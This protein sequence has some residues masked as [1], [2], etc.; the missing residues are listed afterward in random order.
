MTALTALAKRFSLQRLLVFLIAAMLIVAG[1]RFVR[2]RT[3]PRLISGPMLALS[4][5]GTPAIRWSAE[6][7]SQTQSVRLQAA[8]GREQTIGDDGGVARL[9]GLPP[10]TRFKYSVHA[11]WGGWIDHTVAGPFEARVPPGRKEP[12]RFVAFGDSGE[13]GNAQFDLARVM[14]S[15]RP[16]LIIH[17][18]DLIYPAGEASDYLDKFF[19]PYQD[20]IH[21]A[22]FMPSLGNHDCA[23]D[24]GAPLL[25]AFVLP[26]NG[27]AGIDPERNYYFDY[28]PAR[29]VALD[30]N[31]PLSEGGGKPDDAKPATSG[32]AGSAKQKTGGVITDDQ[33]VNIVAP[34]VRQVLTN[35]DARWKLVFFHH[36]Y[37]TGSE[38]PA[39]GADYMK[40]PLAHVFEECGV[41]L[42]FCGHNHLYERTAPIRQDKVVAEGRGV[43]YITTG[44]GGARRYPENLPPP[45]YLRVF[46]AEVF[47]FTQ[48]DLTPATLELRQVDENGR[49]IDEFRLIKGG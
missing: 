15:S 46:N 20:L 1:G 39:S 48:V 32:P 49:V 13:G 43:V 21:S 34:W 25:K 47:S 28:G 29:F 42:V 44:A 2:A 9:G 41:D 10:G 24:H 35:C 45:P 3:Q 40:I 37:Y 16:E 33:R 7:P 18:G 22:Y 17:T 26:E 31:Q 27:P 5:D 11:G 8:D 23:T 14:L 36:P 38:H 6:A 4:A 19:R 30:S 12:F